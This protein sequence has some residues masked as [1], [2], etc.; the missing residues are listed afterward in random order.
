MIEE[1]VGRYLLL[2]SGN[3][4]RKPLP[5]TRVNKGMSKTGAA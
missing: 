2:A 5:R 3:L 4:R 1:A